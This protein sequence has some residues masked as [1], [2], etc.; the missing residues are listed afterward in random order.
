MSQA[1]WMEGYLITNNIIL[2]FFYA[3]ELRFLQPKHNILYSTKHSKL[4]LYDF[5]NI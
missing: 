5:Y 1:L 4:V 2:L 3:S